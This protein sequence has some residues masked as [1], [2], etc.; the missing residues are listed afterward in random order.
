[1]NDKQLVEL[2]KK[3]DKVLKL[4][5]CIDEIKTSKDG[6]VYV[7]FKSNVML[8]T[9]GSLITFTKDGQHINKSSHKSSQPDI[10][11]DSFVID[12]N[13]VLKH[14][15]TIKDKTNK[16]ANE[17]Y[18]EYVN[19]HRNKYIGKL[20]T[21]KKFSWNIDKNINLLKWTRIEVK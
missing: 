12:D 15:D 7:S 20:L 14:V 10:S 2:N 3:L 1:M 11:F 8:E 9:K 4:A 19:K 16:R 17:L 18:V 13:D 21:K 6:S 5:D